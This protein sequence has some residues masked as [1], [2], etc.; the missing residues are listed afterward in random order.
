MSNPLITRL[1]SNQFWYRHWY[2]ANNYSNCLR[3]DSLIEKLLILY[4]NHGLTLTSSPFVHEHWYGR[5]YTKTRLSNATDYSK[6]FRRFFYSNTVVGV[7]HS[8]LL[9]NRTGE[10]FP[11]K[12]WL[13]RYVGWFVISVQW[14][15]P[16]KGKRR[17]VD[18]KRSISQISAATKRTNSPSH[19]RRLSLISS[20]VQNP[21]GR[22]NYNF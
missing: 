15:K 10:Y 14:F 12:V 7:E 17:R 18:S 6:F 4:L 11:M 20:Y 2:S 22:K 21:L 1:G 5:P 19:L 8:Y 16:V 9:R 3:Q 13:F